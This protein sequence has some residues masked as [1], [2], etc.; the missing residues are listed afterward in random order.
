VSSLKDLQQHDVE[1]RFANPAAEDWFKQVAG[2]ASVARGAD[3]RTLHLHVQGDLTEIIRLA[4]E[5]HAT[6][7]ATHEPTL[8]E[9]FLRYYEPEP[10][11]TTLAR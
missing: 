3:E 7:M 6:N 2:V 10:S 4:G 8:E 1:L 5:H 9:V 11:P